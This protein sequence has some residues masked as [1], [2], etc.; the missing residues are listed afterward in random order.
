VLVS[1]WL[2]FVLFK[3]RASREVFETC[4]VLIKVLI[5]SSS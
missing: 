4:S 1:A 2:C 3:G 5:G